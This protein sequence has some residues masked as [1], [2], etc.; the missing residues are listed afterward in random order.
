M[1]NHLPED[2]IPY[3]DYDFIDGD[4]PRDS[5]A[6]VIAVC[7]MNE[8]NVTKKK[9]VPTICQTTSTLG[10]QCIRSTKPTERSKVTPCPLSPPMI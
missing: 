5:S 6:G 8:Q 2:M 7:G 1:L 10:K 3:W 9:T 4:E